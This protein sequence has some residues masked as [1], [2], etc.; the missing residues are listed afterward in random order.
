MSVKINNKNLLYA[1]EQLYLTCPNKGGGRNRHIGGGNPEYSENLILCTAQNILESNEG[2]TTTIQEET[3]QEATTILNLSPDMWVLMAQQIVDKRSCLKNLLNAI[4]IPV[5]TRA[6]IAGNVA[7]NTDK[8]PGS[9]I[10]FNN[11]IEL[12]HDSF[13]KMIDEKYSTLGGFSLR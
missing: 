3:I 12:Y 10:Y 5:E 1:L 7:K 2:I 6:K 11:L 13:R 4:K 9:F 8:G